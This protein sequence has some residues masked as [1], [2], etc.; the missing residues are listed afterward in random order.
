K[1]ENLRA[2][3]DHLLVAPGDDTPVIQQIHLAIAHGI[4]DKIE[5]SMMRK[6]SGT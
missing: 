1:G 4:C 6:N 2:L 5:Q 3:C